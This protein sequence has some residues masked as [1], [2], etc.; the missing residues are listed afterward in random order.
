MQIAAKTAASEARSPD[1]LAE[2]AVSAN[3]NANLLGN[4]RKVVQTVH[5]AAFA[6]WGVESIV[7]LQ[8][9]SWW[10][11]E[12]SRFPATLKSKLRNKAGLLWLGELIFDLRKGTSKTCPCMN[13]E[14]KSK[15]AHKTQV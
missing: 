4:C 1:K 10:R 9:L 6:V 7:L 5:L 8:N 11:N 3:V 12:R 15:S 13:I 14:N 2:R